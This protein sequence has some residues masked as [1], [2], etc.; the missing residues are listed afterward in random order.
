MGR[1]IDLTGQKFGRLTVLCLT[2]ECSGHARKWLCECECGN[3]ITA[4]GSHL[5][6]KIIQSCGCL[7]K[8]L[9]KKYNDYNLDGEYGVG[10]TSNTNEPFYFDIEDFDKIKNYSWSIN[11]DG[12]IV[13]YINKDIPIYPLHR[14]IVKTDKIVDHINHRKYDNRKCNLREVTNQQNTMNQSLKSNNTSGVTGVDFIK[15]T[16]K[17]R[18][19]IKSNNKEIHLGVFDTFDD[20]V[21]A[22]KEAEDKCFGE[23]SYNNSIN[24]NNT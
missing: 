2:N 7:R 15:N 19:R 5:R 22:R 17:W 12:Y 16:S 4:R 18:A 21:K 13:A 8:E 24:L 1:Y 23:Y 20:A 14:L 10:Y 11:S 6:N 3:K 9:K